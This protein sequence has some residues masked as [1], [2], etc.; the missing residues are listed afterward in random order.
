MVTKTVKC[1]ECKTHIIVQG[2]PGEITFLSC[3]NCNTKGKFSFTGKISIIKTNNN[4]NV[5][6]VRNLTKTFNGFNA[7]DNKF[8]GR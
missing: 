3:P 2:N 1:P 5:I 6:E 4:D 7:I 8:I